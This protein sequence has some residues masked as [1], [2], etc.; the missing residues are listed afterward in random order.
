MNVADLL[1]HFFEQLVQFFTDHFMIV[2]A[3]GIFGNA[4][5]AG[6][7]LQGGEIVQHQG[8][9]GTG[10]GY[11]PGRVDTQVKVIF[12]VGHLAMIAFLQPFFKPDGILVQ[13]FGPGNPAVAESKLQGC[14]PDEITML[15]QQ[16]HWLGSSG[17]LK[18]R[19]IYISLTNIDF[20]CKLEDTPSGVYHH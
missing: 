20:F 19:L 6:L 17:K 8:D 4:G 3:K 9:H 11:Q 18:I 13:F 1:A 2:L 16:I 7:L 15:L 14:I 10:P 12:H 5:S